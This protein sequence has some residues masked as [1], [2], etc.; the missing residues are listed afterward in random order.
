MTSQF[1][2]VEE[3]LL[4]PNQSTYDVRCSFSI[5]VR[6]VVVVDVVVVATAAPAT[7]TYYISFKNRFWAL[8]TQLTDAEHEKETRQKERKREREEPLLERNKKT[9]P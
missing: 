3:E 5:I 4:L 7:C 1:G 8:L 9:D 6:V 2:L